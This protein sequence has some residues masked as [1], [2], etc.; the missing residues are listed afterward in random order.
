MSIQGRKTARQIK[1]Y[2]IKYKNLQKYLNELRILKTKHARK[3][4]CDIPLPIG[5]S[6][7]MVFLTKKI[8]RMS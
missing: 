1:E 5:V 6:S 3:I 4:K 2:N 8:N 7:R